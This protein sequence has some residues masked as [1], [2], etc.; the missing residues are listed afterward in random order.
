MLGAGNLFLK[1]LFRQSLP[2][3]GYKLITFA[4]LVKFVIAGLQTVKTYVLQIIAQHKHSINLKRVGL[5]VASS[6][7]DNGSVL[8]AVILILSH[9]DKR[10]LH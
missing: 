2:C 1:P 10:P 5:S 8:I 9:I 6:E 3:K 4:S 7:V